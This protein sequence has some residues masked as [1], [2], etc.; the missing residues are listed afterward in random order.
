M[1]K[2]DFHTI[3]LAMLPGVMAVVNSD[4]VIITSSQD[5]QNIYPEGEIKSIFDIPVAS[6]NSDEW[7]KILC[8]ARKGNRECYI[9]DKNSDEDVYRWDVSL[10]TGKN[11]KDLFIQRLLIKSAR[12]QRLNKLRQEAN[13]VAGVGY[14][15]V[16]IENKT[17]Y[18]STVTRIIHETPENYK[19]TLQEGINFYK[20][21]YYRNKITKLVAEAIRSGKA[22]S[23]ELILVTPKGKEVWVRARG[24]AQFEDGKCVR[25]LGTFQDISEAKNREMVLQK[26]EERF[27]LAFRNTLIAFILIDA[28]TLK[29]KDVN[30]AA[31]EIFGYSRDEFVNL[32]INDIVY[33]ED[34]ESNSLNITRLLSK[35][36][37]RLSFEKRFLHKNGDVID[38]RIFLS[39]TFDQYDSTPATLIAQIQDISELKK[40]SK[41]VDK[42]ID[43]TTR[44]NNRLIDFAHIVS[45][46]LRSHTS[47]ISMLLDFIEKE[48]QD[49]EKELQFNMLKRASN[50]LSETIEHLNGV[51][52]LDIDKQDKI[53]LNLYDY[54][55]QNIASIQ[56]L[57]IRSK[58]EIINDIPKSFRILAVPAY[59]D[60]ILLNLLTNALKY[61]NPDKKSWIKLSAEVKNDCAIFIIEDNGRGID[62][63]R[64]RKKIFG[65]Y[66][67]FHD[68]PE[69]RG[70][71][72][73]MTKRQ[74]EVMGGEIKI[75]SKVNQGTKFK[76]YLYEKS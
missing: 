36:D 73:Y 2:A 41:A 51:I 43:V 19:P 40:K 11:T 64:H 55:V 37:D 59:L 8:N 3:N 72:L 42:F 66:K 24:E 60:S 18:W 56:G 28:Q 9:E 39:V 38:A 21:G 4:G 49:D 32:E 27:R 5:W 65:L 52:A 23:T 71:G 34:I 20:E 50:M 1:E 62:L 75:E 68:H 69:A 76:I 15:E 35:Q 7:E 22:Y 47:N 29:I 74:I 45:H 58:T 14:W 16:D 67:T 53:W 13:R 10:L 30:L 6:L 46:N 61:N 12:N 33:P 48:T 44:Q 70:L 26:S 31:K 63:E 57:I 17:I 25:L 54:T